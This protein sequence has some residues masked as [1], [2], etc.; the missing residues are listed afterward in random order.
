MNLQ[1]RQK[2]LIAELVKQRG[3]MTISDYSQILMVS[4]RT[5]SNDIKAVESYLNL[6]GYSIVRLPGIGLRIDKNEENVDSL[7]ERKTYLG[8]SQDHRIREIMSKILFDEE[9]VTYDSLSESLLVSKTSIKS[10]L[11]TIKNEYL[12][13]TTCSLISGKNGTYLEG[14]EDQ[15]QRTYAKYNDIEIKK[16]SAMTL[17]ETFKLEFLSNLYGVDIVKVCN[18][19]LYEM[20]FENINI[21]DDFYLFNVLNVLIILTYR[22]HLGFHHERTKNEYTSNSG[23][24]I[25]KNC[26]D[27]IGSRLS[28]KFTSDDLTYLSN[29]IKANKLASGI[30]VDYGE[31]VEGLIKNVSEFLSVDLTEDN[32]L[33]EQ[34]YKHFTPMVFRLRNQIINHNPFA[35]Q[36]RKEYSMLFNILVIA[37][38]DTE[39]KLDLMFSADEIGYLLIYFQLAIE[40][41]ESIKKVLIVCPLGISASH[42]L[43]N[44]IQNLLPPMDVVK[45]A[46]LMQLEYLDLKDID[47]VISTLRLELDNLPVIVVSPILTR[48]DKQNIMTYYSENVMDL[49]NLSEDKQ[50]NLFSYIDIKRIFV[51]EVFKSKEELLNHFEARF[52]SKLFDPVFMKTLR[53]RE[54][55]AGTDNPN[56]SAVPHGKPSHVLKT[57]ITIYRLSKKILW[58]QYM[59]NSIIFIHIAE[60]D[61]YLAKEILGNVYRIIK[62]EESLKYYLANKSSKV[63]FELLKG[64][65]N[66][67]K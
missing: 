37:I 18:D 15:K 22:A 28:I 1:K 32:V 17:N 54:K 56:G 14:N 7:S 29:H 66:D 33:F 46:S 52:E 50:V 6:I 47:F 58:D 20:A 11:N 30:T 3:V 64:D 67:F 21:I 36:F 63:I 10:D 44:S 2:T 35:E 31:Y 34:L 41:K 16:A 24:K 40:R 42:L 61:T 45:V 60:K 4:E 51:G 48:E 27:L 23:L 57:G 49:P 65:Q 19:V 25:A 26:L 43:M 55:I 38:H 13:N 39:E 12:N 9:I 62:D 53:D 59:V 5:V 8:T